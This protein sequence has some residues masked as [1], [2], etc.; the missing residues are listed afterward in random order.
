MKNQSMFKRVIK[1]ACL[2]FVLLGVSNCNQF[3]SFSGSESEAHLSANPVFSDPGSTYLGGDPSDEVPVVQVTP[4]PTVTNPT[5]PTPPT[6]PTTT[7]QPPVVVPTPAGPS[8][9]VVTAPVT[10]APEPFRWCGPNNQNFQVLR[11][12]GTYTRCRPCAVPGE[13]VIGDAN[14]PVC[15]VQQCDSRTVIFFGPDTANPNRRCEQCVDLRDSVENGSEPALSQAQ[16]CRVIVPPPP[17]TP[18]PVRPVVQDVP[19]TVTPNPNPRP[20]PTVTTD[21]CRQN[22]RLA[23]CGGNTTT[24]RNSGDGGGDG[25]G[26]P[27][28]IDSEGVQYA[29]AEELR[30]SDASY[31]NSG[32]LDLT[33]PEDGT[34]FN[35]LGLQ[36]RVELDNGDFLHINET[37]KNFKY[38]ISWVQPHQM[39]YRF[40]ALPDANGNINGIDELFGDNTF[41]PD[42]HTPF[43]HDGFQALMKWDRG[44]AAGNFQQGIDHFV[45]DGYIDHNDSVFN[46]LRLW[47]DLNGDGNVSDK[48][49]ASR[50]LVTL[51]SRGIT[52]IHLL[53]NQKFF[54]T[55]KYENDIAYKSIVGFKTENGA[56]KLGT[57][58]DMWFQYNP[59]E[60]LGIGGATREDAETGQFF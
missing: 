11:P 14:V 50:E 18:P 20:T 42:T 21:P 3:A 44:D 47:H 32:D 10:P 27:L 38:Q 6:T 25:G 5:V 41:G 39:R 23:R 26:D 52:Y 12:N 17:V 8:T 59:E 13:R 31:F 57:A 49:E 29:S 2:V 9:P 45:A 51:D 15:E 60:V 55:D 40:L 24:R 7:P 36:D 46:K 56:P 34:K 22:P 54:E 16:A 4:S 28:M 30:N 53:P 19:T 1:S 37:G 43:A 48:D 33:A 35:L 58:F